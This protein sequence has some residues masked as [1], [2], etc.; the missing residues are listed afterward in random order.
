MHW[1]I[2]Y[3]EKDKTIYLKYTGRSE[4]ELFKRSF[5]ECVSLA[6]KFDVIRFLVDVSDLES[7][8]TA[9]D[10]Y[11]FPKAYDRLLVERKTRFAVIQSEDPGI[12][13]NLAF[14]ETVCRNRGYLVK[15]FEDRETA[16]AW[17]QS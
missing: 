1:D 3:S 14:F 15:L 5:E 4:L 11:E 7:A 12:R 17:L 16:A 10:I 8:L 9:V 13:K 2:E 6:T